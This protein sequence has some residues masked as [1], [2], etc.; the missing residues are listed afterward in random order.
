MPSSGRVNA[1]MAGFTPPLRRPI[2]LTTSLKSSASPSESPGASAVATALRYRTSRSVI[3]KASPRTP[4]QGRGGSG[5]FS[6]EG[7]D[8][9]ER[10][11]PLIR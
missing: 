6:P 1:I 2:L 7:G 10:S 3:R 8:S 5:R 9:G 4:K 11:R